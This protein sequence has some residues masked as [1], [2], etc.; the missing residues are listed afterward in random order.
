M[1]FALPPLA[2]GADALTAISSILQAVAAGELT[3][4]EGSSLAGLVEVYPQDRRDRGSGTA[5]CRAGGGKKMSTLKLRVTRLEA[6][7]PDP[8][9]P[10]IGGIPWVEGMTEA[11]YRIAD[12]RARRG[13]H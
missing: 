11:E 9:R 7:R 8:E 10:Y 4:G 12:E 6:K 13:G 2:G 5:H 1:S 3:P